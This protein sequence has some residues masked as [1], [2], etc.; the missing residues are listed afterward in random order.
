MG[1]FGTRVAAKNAIDC[2][3]LA[4]N[5]I[6]LYVDQRKNGQICVQIRQ[7]KPRRWRLKSIA[8]GRSGQ[9]DVVYEPEPAAQE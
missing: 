9:G 8:M 5:G 7:D 3:Q 1:A 2:P 6:T 4:A